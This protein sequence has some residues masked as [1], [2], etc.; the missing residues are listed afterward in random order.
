MYP[1]R[2]TDG[3]WTQ[4]KFHFLFSLVFFFIHL[5]DLLGHPSADDVRSDERITNRSIGY[6]FCY[7]NR[8]KT[9]PLCI[10]EKTNWRGSNDA[11][12]H[13]SSS[14]WNHGMRWNARGADR[15]VKIISIRSSEHRQCNLVHITLHSIGWNEL[16]MDEFH[17][18]IRL[19]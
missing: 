8:L 9:F 4:V 7:L 11:E 6:S 15:T 19:L 3:I 18:S 17:Q 16:M 13:F 12:I 14:P 10:E 5:F 2:S 1:H